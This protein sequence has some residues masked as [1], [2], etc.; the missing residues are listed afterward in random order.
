[1]MRAVEPSQPIASLAGAESAARRRLL[2]GAVVLAAVVVAARLLGVERWVGPAV[3][4]LRGL[5]LAGAALLA[6]A[7]VPAALAGLPMAPLGMAAGAAFGVAAGA[8]IAIPANAAAACLP[9]LVGRLVVGRDPE[10]LARG[11]GRLARAARALGRGGF[12]LVLVLRLSWVAPF[13]LLNYAFGATPCRLRD[14]VLG[15]LIGSAPVS[16]GYAWAGAA[17]LGA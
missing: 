1:M 14:F 10:A 16:L 8:A 17:L 12:R 6:L 13:G 3:A 2:V 5:G 15:T 4:G 7:Y 9:F 11:Q